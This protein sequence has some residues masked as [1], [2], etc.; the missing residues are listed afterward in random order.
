M[1]NNE[2]GVSL[3]NKYVWVL[4][5]IYAEGKISFKDLN[6][7]WLETDYS[8]GREIPKRTF[9]NWKE[10]IL[11]M[12][13]I[14]I[15][16]EKSGQYCYYI[17]NKGDI[18]GDE[19]KS[20]IYKTFSIGNT[21]S[22]CQRIKDRIV[23]E[24]VPSGRVHLQTIV[25][26]MKENRVL[27]ITYQSYFKDSEDTYNV[28]PYCIK[29]FRQ[30]WYLVARGTSPK[31]YKMGPRVYSLDRILKIST[32]DI[33]FDMPEEWN[34]NDY[35]EA[36]FGIFP[37]IKSKIL[38]IKLKATATQA[39][40]IRDLPLHESQI[41]L[42]KN[43]DYSIFS[44]R[45]RATYDFIQEILHNREEVEVLEPQALRKEIKRIIAAMAENYN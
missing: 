30:R 20:W 40:Y 7:K 27:N 11:D 33:T 21:L 9:D 4:D 24:P 31:Y 15:E 34:A 28:Q 17:D 25:D 38:S 43:D 23:L 42:E 45:L 18:I 13:G 5:T 41:E 29:L 19:L 2:R 14:I 35:F 39:S 3:I 8:Q 36:C 22:D 37:N 32:T 1:S 12:F 6:K 10:A 44:Y 26:A 16:N